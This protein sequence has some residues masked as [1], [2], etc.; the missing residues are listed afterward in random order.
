MTTSFWEKRND[1]I[2]RFYGSPS[3]KD[4]KKMLCPLWYDSGLDR[5][6][7]YEPDN[8]NAACISLDTQRKAMFPQQPTET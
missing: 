2:R 5:C 1:A 4:F 8:D 6:F 3:E 7:A